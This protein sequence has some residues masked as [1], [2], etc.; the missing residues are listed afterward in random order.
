MFVGEFVGRAILRTLGV[1]DLNV[2]ALYHDQAGV[3]ALDLGDEL[4]LA[5][6]PGFGGRHQTRGAI[7]GTQHV[8]G[9]KRRRARTAGPRLRCR[10]HVVGRKGCALIGSFCNLQGVV[11]FRLYMLLRCPALASLWFPPQVFSREM[12]PFGGEASCVGLDLRRLSV[13][14][15][16]YGCGGGGDVAWEIVLAQGRRPRVICRKWP[17]PSCDWLSRGVSIINRVTGLGASLCVRR[18]KISSSYCLL[19][20][21]FP[22]RPY[23]VAQ[24]RAETT[25]KE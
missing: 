4:L 25:K 9:Q 11:P 15:T 6:G 17:K 19:T 8:L 2:F 18:G 22:Y 21:G 20:E 10:P 3:D 13:V 1:V 23:R 12:A 7:L 14:A 24:C 5:D 16:W